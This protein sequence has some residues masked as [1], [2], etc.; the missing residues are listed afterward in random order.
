MGHKITFFTKKIIRRILTRK[1]KSH[2]MTQRIDNL[3]PGCCY[4]NKTTWRHV[5]E[6]LL[7]LRQIIDSFSFAEIFTTLIQRTT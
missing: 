6:K 1:R 5:R 4:G 3:N 2:D 7:K